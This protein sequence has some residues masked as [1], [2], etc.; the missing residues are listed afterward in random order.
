MRFFM[1]RILCYS[2]F[3]LLMTIFLLSACA[4]R[5]TI[6]PGPD[7][8]GISLP[9]T[10]SESFSFRINDR[11]AGQAIKKIQ[12][13]KLSP[14]ERLEVLLLQELTA[15]KQ[16]TQINNAF[17]RVWQ[18]EKALHKIVEQEKAPVSSR[19][20]LAL[21]YFM[22]TYDDTYDWRDQTAEKIY[23]QHIL[24][25][26]DPGQLAG[27]PLHF[28][29]LA[30]LQNSHFEKAW[31]GLKHLKKITPSDVYLDNLTIA[32]NYAGIKA[33]PPF[34]EKIVK[35]MMIYC[36][37]KEIPLPDEQLTATLENL[38]TAGNLEP[39]AKILLNR[40]TVT[41]SIKK[42][43]FYQYLAPFQKTD[44]NKSALNLRKDAVRFRVQTIAADN[45]TDYIDP[46]LEKIGPQLHQ[47]LQ[48]SQIYLKK[49][50][51]FLLTT[52]LHK[53]LKMSNHYHLD[54]W[55]KNVAPNKARFTV[56]IHKKENQI[57]KTLIETVDQGETIIAGPESDDT[58]LILR[59]TTWLTGQTMNEN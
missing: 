38:Q 37:Q 58:R 7:P 30:L 52:G 49:E 32:L 34:A 4:G 31:S 9:Q 26:I 20:A 5:Q 55:L 14:A 10:V 25:K 24:Q 36:R 2:N 17:D 59:I 45:K 22:L 29:T 56:A 53:Q 21:A 16:P 11:Q 15:I 19:P 12:T 51:Y 8:A 40:L 47:T 43:T 39:V 35:H 46:A 54:V 50:E 27:Y 1:K 13:K 3:F 42:Y 41:D 44:V 48:A 33:N 28:Y 18:R 23:Q 57:K 6:K